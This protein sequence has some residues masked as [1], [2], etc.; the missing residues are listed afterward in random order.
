MSNLSGKTA[1]VTGAG[2]GI[3]RA[4]ARRL[5]EDGAEVIITGRTEAT[6]QEA[7]GQHERIAYLVA[8]LGR[9]EDL[10]RVIERI[11]SGHGRLDILVNNAGT[12][13]VTPFADLDMA[14]FDRVFRSNVRGL[15]ELTQKALPLLRESRGNVVN[16]S[17]SITGRPMANMGIYAASKAAV[18]MLTRVWAK[19]L[20][21]DGIRVNSV[22][23]G[24]IETPI[25]D[26]TDL[27]Q[28]AAQAHLDA[29]KKTV[30]LGRFGTVEEVTSVV[31]F[32]ASDEASF[33]TGSDY[34]VDGG[35]A[36]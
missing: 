13:P 5:A 33:V 30:P 6:L 26:K 1:L 25:Y 16:I 10:G 31:A 11:A 3:G 18:N 4:I 7:A 19:E 2:T 15:V 27:S 8:D 35:C 21:A 36:A 32:L 28:E 9:S 22:G 24:P 12:A 23:V 20:A 14:E 29:V 17:T 34:A